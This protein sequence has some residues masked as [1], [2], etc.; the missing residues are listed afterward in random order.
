M[1]LSLRFL[2]LL[3]GAGAGSLVQIVVALLV[4]AGLVMLGIEEG[5]SVVLLPSLVLGFLVGGFVAGR[6]SFHSARLHGAATGILI[7]AVTVVTA[8][9]GGSDAGVIE[10]LILAV[11][12]ML[13]GGIGG[14]MSEA[15]R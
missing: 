3:I 5:S 2:A 14:I 9:R 13:F 15:R 6:M 1:L 7:A 11:V 4:G 10:V 8:R 12:A